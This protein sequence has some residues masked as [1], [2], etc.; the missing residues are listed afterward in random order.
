MEELP[1]DRVGAVLLVAW[2]VLAVVALTTCLNWVNEGRPRGTAQLWA[3]VAFSY[4]AVIGMA[5][6]VHLIDSRDS[7]GGP[8]SDPC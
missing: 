4:L 3:Y 8:A 7:Q 1:E 6:T 2:A 5:L